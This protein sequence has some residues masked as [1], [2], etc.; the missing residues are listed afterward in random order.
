MKIQFIHIQKLS[1]LALFSLLLIGCGPT[2]P[3]LD[4]DEGEFVGY[5]V[6]YE[7]QTEQW[8]D[9]DILSTPRLQ[10]VWRHPEQTDNPKEGIWSM[11]LD[12]SDL[13]QV[14][15]RELLDQPTPGGTRN[16]RLPVRSPN[17]RYIALS[18]LSGCNTCAVVRIVDLETQTVKELDNRLYDGGQFYQWSAD[19]RYLVFK[20]RG[21]MIEH[22]MK[23]DTTQLIT[24]RFGEGYR[25]GIFRLLDGGSKLYFEDDKR[26]VYDYHTGQFLYALK[27]R[28]NRSPLTEDGKYYITNMK[29]DPVLG[30]KLGISTFENPYE[31]V[32]YLHKEMGWGGGVSL[33][34]MGPVYKREHNG[35]KMAHLGENKITRYELPGEAY[36][37]NLSLYNTAKFINQ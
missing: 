26:Y 17:N 22:D 32:A 28:A 27:G 34:N 18:M 31:P 12:G 11:R 37:Y 30:S 16:E 29:K 20:G 6:H 5:K 21:G 33:G 3:T 14:A 2:P 36:I 10:F 35:I 13:R 15:S 19:S 9:P 25:Q 24:K 1:A 7:F 8:N 4:Y 23:T